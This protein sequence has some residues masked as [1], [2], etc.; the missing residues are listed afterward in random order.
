MRFRITSEKERE[1]VV[2]QLAEMMRIH[3][4]EEAEDKARELIKSLFDFNMNSDDEFDVVYTFKLNGGLLKVFLGKA[5]RKEMKKKN[6]I[7]G[8]DINET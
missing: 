6:K 8:G 1:K 7:K 3:I 2:K 5:K 4:N